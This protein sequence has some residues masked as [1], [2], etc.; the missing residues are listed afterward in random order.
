MKKSKDNWN[1]N[2][3]QGRSRKH[4]DRNNAGGAIS[5]GWLVLF[6]FGV[7]FWALSASIHIWWP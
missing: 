4:V 1:R 2:E 3:W 7:L 6:V 5:L